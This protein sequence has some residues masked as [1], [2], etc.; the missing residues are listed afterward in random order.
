MKS[1]R[2]FIFGALLVAL[3]LSTAGESFAQ[4]GPGRGRGG[5]L[6]DVRKDSA[7]KD[8]GRDSLFR[9][10]HHRGLHHL[11]GFY[12]NNDSCREV[13]LSQMS[14]EDAAA[15]T[16]AVE[17]I[18]RANANI[19]DLREQLRRAKQARNEEAFREISAQLKSMYLL[20]SGFQR[21]LAVILAKYPEAAMR[22]QK[23]CGRKPKGPRD[24][25]ARD[26]RKDD[27]RQPHGMITP[28]PVELGGTAVLNLNLA[29]EASVAVT[30]SNESGTVL[31]IPAA[32]L[33]AGEQ[34]I[35][36]DVSSLTRGAYLVQVQ[37]GD[38]MQVLKLMIR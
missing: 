17:S 3:G 19:A 2:Y 28:N 38:K 9:K 34:Q 10:D 33:A 15:F 22:V 21:E 11:I 30:I 1:F 18:K 25:G 31:T 36:L 14:P 20:V 5:N 13:L 32:Q 12:V 24:G 16:T 29:T 8:N 4:K 35:N 27:V 37:I 23:E 7:R 6:G 26:E